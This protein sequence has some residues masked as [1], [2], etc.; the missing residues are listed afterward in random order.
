V[1]ADHW[2]DF[3]NKRIERAS[4]NVPVIHTEQPSYHIDTQGTTTTCHVGTSTAAQ[5]IQRDPA[6]VPATIAEVPKEAP[7]ITDLTST[8]DAIEI[9][10][11]TQTHKEYTSF[12]FALVNVSD[13]IVRPRIDVVA[14]LE[15]PILE[16]VAPL[17]KKMIIDSSGNFSS[18]ASS[19]SVTQIV[20]VNTGDIC[21]TLCKDFDL[22][23]QVLEQ[24]DENNAPFTPVS[25]KQRKVLN[26]SAYNTRSKDDPPTT[27]Q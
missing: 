26:R 3:A 8:I 20:E 17:E 21:P 7:K 23:R 13:E 24:K 25:T 4:T 14:Q 1:H 5:Q 6:A 16:R 22:L 19:A 27:S 2:T 9:V 12:H 15:N 11:E 18:P 10:Q